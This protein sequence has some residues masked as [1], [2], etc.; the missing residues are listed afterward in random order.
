[1]RLSAA[2]GS[3]VIALC[4]CG[5]V[6][7]AAPTG[8]LAEYVDFVRELA[9]KPDDPCFP[10]ESLVGSGFATRECKCEYRLVFADSRY[11]S[12]YARE[13]RYAGGAHGNTTITVGTFDRRTGRRVALDDAFPAEARPGLAA[14][15]RQLVVEK[16]G[17]EEHLQAEVVPTENFCLMSD[18][19]HFVYNEY[20]VACYADG[21]VEVVIGRER[22]R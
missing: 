9:A 20:E 19:W 6:R 22:S 3:A 12:F 1:M 7:T 8:G 13:Y 10:V 4:G 15:L 11:V 21:A 17:G 5:G 2:M 14:Q 18:G 16:L